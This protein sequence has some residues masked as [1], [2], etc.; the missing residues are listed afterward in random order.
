[1]RLELLERLNAVVHQREARALAAAVLRPEAED[2]DLVLGRL[3][4]FRQL[5]AELVL[6]DVGAVRVE[7]VTVSGGGKKGVVRWVIGF[8]MVVGVVRNGGGRREGRG[9]RV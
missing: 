3:V 1:M 4:H 6:G 7:D 5:G 9:G 8:E 2:A